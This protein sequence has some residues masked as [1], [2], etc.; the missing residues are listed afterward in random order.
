MLLCKCPKKA[1]RILI[2]WL[3]LAAIRLY[4]AIRA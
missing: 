4:P 3:T 1:A 2:I